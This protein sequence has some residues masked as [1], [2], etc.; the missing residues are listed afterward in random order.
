MSYWDKVID[1]FFNYIYLWIFI[2]YII[3]ALLSDLK[4]K[5]AERFFSNWEKIRQDAFNYYWNYCSNCWIAENLQVHHKIPR[6]LGWTDN[7]NNLIVLC[8]DCHEEEHWYKFDDS[9][10]NSMKIA[11]NKMKR[12]NN[13]IINNEKLIII[14]NN[15]FKWETVKR[16]I[17]PIELYKHD[18]ISKIWSTWFH[19][20]VRAYCYLRNWER[21]FQIRK[22]KEIL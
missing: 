22:I 1:T 10:I 5:K 4:N 7:I 3:W 9:Q 16:E 12:I 20:T 13:A 19:W 18:Y 8:K 21:N 2:F 6:S 11:S 17:K 14:Y 15:T